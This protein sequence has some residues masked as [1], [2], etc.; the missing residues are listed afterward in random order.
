[1]SKIVC[2]AGKLF[3][4]SDGTKL[5]TKP[6]S[7]GEIK[8][9]PRRNLN[10]K[11]A[12]SFHFRLGAAAVTIWEFFSIFIDNAPSFSHREAVFW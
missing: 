9:R 4:Y 7:N 6:I 8:K 3:K 12:L 10:K 1:M 2:R 5:N 11:P